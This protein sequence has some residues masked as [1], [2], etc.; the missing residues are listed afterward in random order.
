ML[1]EADDN[2]A[3][4]AEAA[5]AEEAL[6]RAATL[7]RA[8]PAASLPL[9]AGLIAERRAALLQYAASGALCRNTCKRQVWMAG[10]HTRLKSDLVRLSKAHLKVLIDKIRVQLGALAHMR[11]E[12]KQLVRNRLHS[13]VVRCVLAGAHPSIALGQLWWL[14]RM[15][16]ATLADTAHMSINDECE[17]CRRRPLGRA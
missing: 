10:K 15:A 14:F 13:E 2:D 3:E 9:L 7:G 4:E 1:Q 5:L 11:N 17:L 16:G 8:S 6:E 12:P